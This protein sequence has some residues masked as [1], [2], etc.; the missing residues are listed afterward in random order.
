M[1][2]RCSSHTRYFLFWYFPICQER[3]LH[4]CL[5]QDTFR[6]AF[7]QPATSSIERR[8]DK[9]ALVLHITM[10]PAHDAQF[11]PFIETNICT[12][13][14]PLR[15]FKELINKIWSQVE[16]MRQN[17]TNIIVVLPQ[18][19]YER[20][21]KC[22]AFVVLDCKMIGFGI[23][24]MA[25]NLWQWW[26]YHLSSACAM[27]CA[28]QMSIV[29]TSISHCNIPQ[30]KADEKHIRSLLFNHTSFEQSSF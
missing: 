19:L 12:H 9:P 16:V 24:E 15:P 22:E 21:Q 27:A 18:G 30:V 10:L 13:S 6:P 1:N 25:W 4:R 3:W 26:C 5:L 14:K 20:A 11:S 29:Y 2:W 17:H 23:C 28:S 7:L 8:L